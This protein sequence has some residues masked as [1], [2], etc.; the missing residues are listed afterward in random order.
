MQISLLDIGQAV[1]RDKTW[2]HPIQMEQK[3]VFF[4]SSTFLC[5]LTLKSRPRCGL[6]I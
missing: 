2:I 3:I 4:T 1:Y 5:H 6:L